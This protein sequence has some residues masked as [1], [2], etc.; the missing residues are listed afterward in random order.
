M[1]RH[2]L[3]NVKDRDEPNN[4]QGAVHKIKCSDC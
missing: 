1:L 2:L 4:K 3:T